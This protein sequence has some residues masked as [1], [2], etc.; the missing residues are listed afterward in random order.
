MG[1]FS[2]LV[3][4]PTP[5]PAKEA[6]MTRAEWLVSCNGHQMVTRVSGGQFTPRKH[7]LLACGCV[8]YHVERDRD[9]SGGSNAH[10]ELYAPASDA[11]GWLAG[12]EAAADS[13]PS[14]R[15]QYSLSIPG[16]KAHWWVPPEALAKVVRDLFVYPVESV[17]SVDAWLTPT[18]VALAEV[19]DARGSF[20]DMPV[21]GDA[22]EDAGCADEDV[23][24]HCRHE[25]RHFRG[26]WVL[27]ALLQRRAGCW[28]DAYRAVDRARAAEVPP[29]KVRDVLRPSA[30]FP[31]GHFLVGTERSGYVIA[32]WH[33]EHGV[34]TMCSADSPLYFAMTEHMLASGA[35]RFSSPWEAAES[36]RGAD[37][38]R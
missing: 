32:V 11:P 20:E 33:H 7:L 23:L 10:P 4:T 25:S 26:C 13:N 9:P 17:P 5:E 16:Q 3:G 8:R 24:H 34:C 18:V 37:G 35:A 27:D 12:A 15:E 19:I 14:I 36:K 1:R 30:E 29:E 2:R 6:I 22:L 31:G 28:R 21:L 38:E